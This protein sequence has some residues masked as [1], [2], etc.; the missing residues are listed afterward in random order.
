MFRFIWRLIV[1]LSAALAASCGWGWHNSYKRAD[2]AYVQR[3]KRYVQATVHRG[4]INVFWIDD[5]PE[6]EKGK[7]PVKGYTHEAIGE[8]GLVKGVTTFRLKQESETAYWPVTL[9]N[10]TVHLESEQKKEK[11]EP[12]TRPAPTPT[13]TKSRAIVITGGPLGVSAE[14]PAA[15]KRAAETPKQFKY[16]AFRAPHWL[17]L[18]IVSIPFALATLS[19]LKL[20]LVRAQRRRYGQCV[21]CGYDLRGVLDGRCPQCRHNIKP[22]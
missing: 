10:G 5:Y 16:R 6:P 12:A 3:D 15:K 19:I 1:L 21:R 7:P 22:R 13:T 18:A 8:D 9:S 11:A 20:P 14:D 2:S 17:V 4:Q